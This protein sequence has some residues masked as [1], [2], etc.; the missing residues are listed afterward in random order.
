MA[1][2]SQENS[3]LRVPGLFLSD[4]VLF[5]PAEL[6]HTTAVLPLC[7]GKAVSGLVLGLVHW[8][9]RKVRA[10]GDGPESFL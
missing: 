8:E 2:P 3:L 9:S 6:S 7:P 10:S 4:G 5:S 1:Y